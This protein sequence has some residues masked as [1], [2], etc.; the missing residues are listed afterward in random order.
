MGVALCFFLPLSSLA[1]LNYLFSQ[2][3][4]S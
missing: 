4:L 1:P 3:G 2:K